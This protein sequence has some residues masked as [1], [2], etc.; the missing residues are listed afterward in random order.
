[1]FWMAALW[2]LIPLF[3]TGY[4]R[5]GIVQSPVRASL[6]LAAGLW[7]LKISRSTLN[8][9]AF[10]GISWCAAVSWGY[11]LPILFAI[12]W[13]WAGMEWTRVLESGLK[14]VSVS[15]SLGFLMLVSLLLAFRVG[16]EFVYRDGRRS[17]MTES[18]GAVF[19][20]LSG[21]YSDPE[22]AELYK[23]LKVLAARYGPNFKTMPAFPQANFLT[24]TRPALPLDWVV[25]RE[26]NNDNQLVFKDLKEKHPIVFIQKSFQEKWKTDAELEV[27]RW[28]FEHGE[29]IAETPGFWVLTNYE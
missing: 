11:N 24:N 15:K 5:K 19:P 28:L 10:L 23:D 25:N 12:P 22:T 2:C 17:N 21:I 9:C 13:V 26:T 29:I 8:H 14:P 18:M 20:R 6:T 7:Q 1:M 16:Y 4:F 27:T 3:P